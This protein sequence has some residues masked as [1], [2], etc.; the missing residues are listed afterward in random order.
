MIPGTQTMYPICP[1]THRI[2]RDT[3]MNIVPAPP[4]FTLLAAKAH[5]EI[6]ITTGKSATNETAR[7]SL[8]SHDFGP[9]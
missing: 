1:I 3:P 4:K 5:M 7:F 6:S 8:T 2:I 9:R